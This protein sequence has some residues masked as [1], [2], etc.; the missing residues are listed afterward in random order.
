MLA[1]LLCCLLPSDPLSVYFIDVEGGGAMLVV[2]PEGESMLVDSGYPDLGSRDLKRILRVVKD[3]ADLD[4]I[5]HAV[6]THWHRDHYGNHAALAAELPIGRFLDRGIPDALQ[7]DP[8]F[9][10]RIADYRRASENESIALAAGDDFALAG[11]VSVRVLAA[12]R[13]V[14]S[15]GE[16]NPYASEHTARD[17]DNSDNAESLAMVIEHG[18]FRLF[19]GGDLTWNVEADLVTPGNPIGSIDLYMVTHHGLPTSNN[20]VL[21]KAVEPVVAVMC[22]G[23]S[24]GGQ[25]DVLA[26][27]AA[28]PTLKAWFQLHTNLSVPPEKQTKRSRIANTGDTASCSGRF[29][30]VTHTAGDNEF[31]V[32]IEGSEPERFSTHASA[33]K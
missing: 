6:V 18:D 16:P 24:K 21:V 17:R 26:T 28:L 7:E 3:V 5:D 23:P 11:G 13:S 20:P 2:S 19:C 15:G 25:P 32:Q 10:P 9:E 30:R 4:R 31:A 22:N 27:L 14:V 33:A 1:A 29:I 12:S 8:E